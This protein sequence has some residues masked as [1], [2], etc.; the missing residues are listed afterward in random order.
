MP[1][2]IPTNSTRDVPRAARPAQDISLIATPNGAILTG[3][4]KKYRTYQE[5]VEDAQ[6]M[7]LASVANGSMDETYQVPEDH[8]GG[9][10]YERDFVNQT[11]KLLYS[12]KDMATSLFID[13]SNILN[14]PAWVGGVSN[15]R[16]KLTNH[17]YAETRTTYYS[18]GNYILILPD[19]STVGLGAQIVLE[20]YNGQGTVCVPVVSIGMPGVTLGQV[21]PSLSSSSLY[22]IARTDTAMHTIGTMRIPSSCSCSGCSGTS[23][24]LPV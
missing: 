8:I 7:R 22:T 13:W 6:P 24:P 16:E 23:C 12:K 19:P 21:D 10:L 18:Y 14:I 11:W 9:I 2:P 5:M 3:E 1:T 17:R 20:Q 15:K 4:I